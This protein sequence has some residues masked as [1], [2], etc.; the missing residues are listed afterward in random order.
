M[1]TQFGDRQAHDRPLNDRVSA[2][3]DDRVDEVDEVDDKS[4]INDRTVEK[5]NDK[6][7]DR[8]GDRTGSKP[9]DKSVTAD[10]TGDKSADKS[11]TGDSVTN[12]RTG[13]RTVINDPGPKAAAHGL[14]PRESAPRENGDTL[15]DAQAAHEFR[16]DW[17][18]LAARFVDDP[19]AAVHDAESLLAKMMD[20]LKASF[21][22]HG[23]DTEDL[24][25]ALRR[26][27]SLADQILT[28]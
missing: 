22:N 5:N 10:K 28:A 1:S 6:T 2:V 25:R 26:Y 8:T 23:H 9:A 21:E 7:G 19:S 13:D 12:D 20:D 27:R 4:V 3:D 15:F 16:T 11:V 18:E 24:R 17:R 14:D